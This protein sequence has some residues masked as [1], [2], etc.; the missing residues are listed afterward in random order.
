M[1]HPAHYQLD[2]LEVIDVIRAAGWLPEFCKANALKYILRAGS[3]GGEAEDLRKAAWYLSH[4][5]GHLEAMKGA[6]AP[7]EPEPEPAGGEDRYVFE[8][9]VR[10]HDGR[11]WYEDNIGTSAMTMLQ[12]CRSVGSDS[13]DAAL[14]DIVGHVVSDA[15][16]GDR[17]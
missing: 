8:V 10:L 12:L 5:A 1:N 2:G 6:D 15:A 4:L 16:K 11:R 7:A 3:K 17:P 14:Q 9:A 13:F